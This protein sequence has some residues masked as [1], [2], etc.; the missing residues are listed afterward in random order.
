MVNNGNE[1]GREAGVLPA[2][3][4]TKVIAETAKRHYIGAIRDLACL[5]SARLKSFSQDHAKSGFGPGE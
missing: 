1:K 5:A 2:R 3:H 4:G